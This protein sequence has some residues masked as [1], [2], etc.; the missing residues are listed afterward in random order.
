L[1]SQQPGRGDEA[2]A[3]YRRAAELDARDAWHWNNLGLLLSEQPSRRDEAEAAYRRAAEL[4]PSD[5]YPAANLARLFAAEGRRQE[6][7]AAYRQAATLAQATDEQGPG[8]ETPPLDQCF[9][10]AHVLLQAH[11]WL[12]NRDL[13]LQA[14]DHLTEAA[15][16]GDRDAFY[17]LKEQARECQHIGLGSALKGLMEASAWADF[18]QPFALALGAAALDVTGDALAGAPPELRTLA[19]EILAELRPASSAGEQRSAQLGPRG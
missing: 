14:L 18:L 5:P 19:E 10:H 8:A 1:L 16:A 12:G 11:L 15:A 17:R 2:E 9:G 13:A 7:D 3:A 4:D 6:A